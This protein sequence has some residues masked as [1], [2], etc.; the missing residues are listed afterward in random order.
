M[1][2]SRTKRVSKIAGEDV[3]RVGRT[4]RPASSSSAKKRAPATRPK[5][6]A[7]ARKRATKKKAAVQER[8]A[9]IRRPGVLGEIRTSRI[10]MN[11][12]A[13]ERNCRVCK[14]C[15]SHQ[16]LFDLV[17]GHLIEGGAINVIHQHL[18][19]EYPELRISYDSISR[20]RSRHLKP[21]IA[22][23]QE[24]RIMGESISEAL[25]SDSPV[26]LAITILREI[27]I[28]IHYTIT[29]L[30]VGDD[31][32]MRMML[33]DNFQSLLRIGADVAGKLSSA[34]RSQI[35]TELDRANLE[36]KK[37][38]VAMRSGDHLKA[39]RALLHQAAERMSPETR[40]EVGRALDELAGDAPKELPAGKSGPGGDGK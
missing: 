39:V 21:T 11:P 26:S 16:D 35:Q 29:N 20:H 38:L 4:S 17:N 28:A 7:P 27:A 22:R 31:D 8:L 40:A 5:K 24:L 18:K 13:R 3:G 23:A 19:R 10:R 32:A 14:L 15:E 12:M 34:E 9:D 1:P 36:L 30:L 2:K 25:G 37:L 33:D 6:R